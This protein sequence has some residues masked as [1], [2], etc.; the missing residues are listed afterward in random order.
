MHGSQQVALRK[1]REGFTEEIP[2][3][4]IDCD[5]KYRMG[6]ELNP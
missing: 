3:F 1:N 6:K 4:I 5:V 2:G